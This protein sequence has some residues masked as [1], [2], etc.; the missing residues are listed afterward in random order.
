MSDARNHPTAVFHVGDGVFLDTAAAHP[1]LVF[2]ITPSKVLAFT[3]NPYS[4]T[5]YVP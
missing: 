1:A 4:Q 5:R 3:K 2:A